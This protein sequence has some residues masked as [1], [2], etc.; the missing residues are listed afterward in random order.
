MKDL[1]K[2]FI[3]NKSNYHGTY[4]SLSS[5]KELKE[6]VYRDYNLIMDTT[7]K[8]QNGDQISA[9]KYY[10]HNLTNQRLQNFF[11]FCEE[12]I[13]GYDGSIFAEN[14]RNN[15]DFFNT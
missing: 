2:T 1:F 3:Q 7:I 4:K 13:Q 6:A 9:D 11:D 10:I 8:L 12:N 5:A 15:P 14:I